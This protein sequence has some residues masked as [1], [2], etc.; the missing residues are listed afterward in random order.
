MQVANLEKRQRS[1][2]KT[3]PG[4]GGLTHTEKVGGV[5]SLLTWCIDPPGA[6]CHITCVKIDFCRPH[7]KPNPTGTVAP[8]FQNQQK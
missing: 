5:G 8:F 1:E 7:P 6:V 3:E 4:G 2:I